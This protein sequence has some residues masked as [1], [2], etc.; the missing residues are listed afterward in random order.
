M[1]K[2]TS[3]SLMQVEEEVAGLQADLK[4]EQEAKLA[5][6]AALADREKALQ[7]T[8]DALEL[9][10]RSCEESETHR[11]AA[12]ERSSASL[13]KLQ[14]ELADLQ[15]AFKAEQE[16]KS[17]AEATSADVERAVAVIKDDLDLA[18]RRCEEGETSRIAAEE[19]A[20]AA[21]T[22]LEVE[23]AD[24][25]ADLKAE[26]EACLA[27]EAA[28]A[29]REKALQTTKN[30]LERAEQASET[31][32]NT[33]EADREMHRI[34]LERVIA[35]T[36]QLHQLVAQAEDIRLKERQTYADEVQLS[37]AELEEAQA[38]ALSEASAAL[39]E[40]LAL[41]AKLESAEVAKM[42]MADHAKQEL[43]AG[44]VEMDTRFAAESKLAQERADEAIRQAND[45]VKE[46]AEQCSK[47]VAQTQQQ[48][49]EL[50]KSSVRRVRAQGEDRLERAVKAA[51]LEAQAK[52]DAISKDSES[53]A[54]RHAAWSQPV[55]NMAVKRAIERMYL[56]LKA[57]CWA[58]WCRYARTAAQAK[59][60]EAARNRIVAKEEEI[61]EMATSTQAKGAEIDRLAL[62]LKASE[63]VS[64][65][66]ALAEE[67][68]DVVS[69]E[70]EE[71]TA[72][73]EATI[74]EL[75][76][77]LEAARRDLR[78]ASAEA[79]QAAQQTEDAHRSF[80]EQLE[81]QRA[82]DRKDWER[83]CGPQRLVHESQVAVEV[84]EARRAATELNRL[85]NQHEE[86]RAIDSKD[87]ERRMEAQ[88]AA[89]ES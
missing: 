83:H 15:T 61:G 84:A 40:R 9:A 41:E 8:K 20:S 55:K 62:E 73:S 38:S 3:S 42:E 11:I 14:E 80:D 19:Q 28:L 77:S 48:A 79:Q 7:A 71:N 31:L 75:E 88:Q 87:F 65:L 34:E 27:T 49:E 6:D 5:T 68:L 12:E 1:E 63:E 70:H 54:Q 39:T 26:Q 72:V 24:L 29:E 89:H 81:Q 67:K 21:L 86:Q 69:R 44:Q 57:R 36:A 33:L 17:A 47:R 60:E 78:A 10:R 35:E 51:Q 50:V 85:G 82:N 43:D 58:S 76:S 32:A 52:I 59:L 53:A 30:D 18:R 2:R 56:T 23:I 37:H 16:A 25:R 64:A 46:M 66:N 22:K 45:R 13:A 74:A 4:A